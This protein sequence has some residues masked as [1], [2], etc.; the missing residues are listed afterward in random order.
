[1]TGRGRENVN[2]NLRFNST[3]SRGR[4][5]ATLALRGPRKGVSN[6][7]KKVTRVRS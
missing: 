1:M 3:L 5:L 2:H 6:R 4:H 7:V